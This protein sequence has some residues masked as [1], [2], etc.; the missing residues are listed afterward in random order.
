MS[1]PSSPGKPGNRGSSKRA[2]KLGTRQD[3]PFVNAGPNN[4]NINRERSW[5]TR[6]VSSST[7]TDVVSNWKGDASELME[8]S[9]GSK[10]G[11][12]KEG[13][14]DAALLRELAVDRGRA[15]FLGPGTLTLF[16]AFLFSSSR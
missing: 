5:Q 6:S 15:H 14:L 13:A 10:D 9:N 8:R 2:V 12:N 7:R 11:Q 4:R 16:R 1:Q 3:F